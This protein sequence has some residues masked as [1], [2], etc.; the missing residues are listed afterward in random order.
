MLLVFDREMQCEYR[1]RQYKVRDNGSVFRF[2]KDGHKPSKWDNIWTFGTKDKNDGYMNL[3]GNISIHRIVCTAFHGPE[4]MPN[5]VV[6]H[7]DTNRCNNRPENLRWLTRLENILLNPATKK[8]II[9]LCGSIEAFLN[10]PAILRDKAL[11]PNLEWMR[12]VTKEEAAV[13]KR[14]MEEWSALESS[15][16]KSS[17]GR[18]V[19]LSSSSGL[20]DFSFSEEEMAMSAE[21]NKGRSYTGF[22]PEKDQNNN[23]NHLHSDEEF[24]PPLV[25][26]LTSGVKQVNWE[27]PSVFHCC[28]KDGEE[29]TLQK[30]LNNLIKKKPFST[31]KYGHRTTV[32]KAEY[33]TDED[34][35]YVLSY[36]KERI[37]VPWGICRITLEDGVF[38]HEALGT[39]QSKIGG[40]KYFRLAMGKE[41]NGPECIDDFLL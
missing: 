1:G 24:R 27:T 34:A 39:Y 30:Y 21:W 25:D 16:H 26:A 7:I 13:C 5:M 14:R 29:R 32:E 36:G 11:P 33:H 17:K 12:S 2:P 40:H 38:I 9:F 4:P 19:P 31:D 15:N 8:K 20:S 35:L 41:W 28:P 6:D 10:N 37:P 3:T 22:Y 23:L 18:F